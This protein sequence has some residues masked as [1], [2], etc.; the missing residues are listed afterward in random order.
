LA[1]TLTGASIVTHLFGLDQIG[2]IQQIT[3]WSVIG[4]VADYFLDVDGHGVTAQIVTSPTFGEPNPIGGF[5]FAVPV[6]SGSVVRLSFNTMLGTDQLS[7]IVAG[8]I[9]PL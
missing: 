8:Y 4:G 5:G 7:F 1:D 2:V 9:E 6:E 3:G